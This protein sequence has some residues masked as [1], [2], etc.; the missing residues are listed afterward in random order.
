MCPL[1]PAAPRQVLCVLLTLGGCVLSVRAGKS[2]NCKVS[3]KEGQGC[4]AP[5]EHAPSC[6][7][8]IPEPFPWLLMGQ[9]KPRAGLTVQVLHPTPS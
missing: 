3:R 4:V 6:P 1:S 5:G 8:R 2:A 7:L 9:E